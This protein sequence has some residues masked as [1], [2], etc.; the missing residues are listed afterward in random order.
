MSPVALVAIFS[1]VIVVGALGGAAI[2]L[3]GG[4]RRMTGFLTLA[5]G[6][7]FGAIFFDMLPEAVRIGGYSCLSILPLGFAVIFVLERYVLA[8]VC[9]EPPDFPQHGHGTMGLAAF[10]GLSAHTL[11]DG[12][13]LAS[14]AAEGVGLLTFLAVAA[15]KIPASFSLSSILMSEHRSKRQI[16]AWALVFGLM[17]P[18]GAVIYFA[19]ASVVPYASFAPD[20]LAFSAGTFLYIATSDLL[21]QINRHKEG[22]KVGKLAAFCGGLAIMLLL[23]W[24]A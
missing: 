23:S 19:I 17:V 15:H 10:L 1:A 18:V 4:E 3:F 14:S 11:F 2:P 7:M 8:H 16:L 12:V 13:A 22:S 21:P 20:A 5:A 24:A 6:V 9:E